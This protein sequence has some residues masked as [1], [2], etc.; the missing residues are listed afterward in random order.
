MVLGVE[1]N[2]VEVVVTHNL[3]VEGFHSLVEVEGIAHSSLGLAAK[4][5]LADHQEDHHTVVP[6]H[7]A[8]VGSL[9]V[10]DRWSALHDVLRKP[11]QMKCTRRLDVKLTFRLGVLV[12]LVFLIFLALF[13]F[14]ALFSFLAFLSFLVLL[15]L[16][17][18]LILWFII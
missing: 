7:K 3:E 17:S 12:F 6:R 16:V 10:E 14:L 9:L 2:L 8:G 13:A 15:V 5:G 4:T 1:H 18:L 11:K